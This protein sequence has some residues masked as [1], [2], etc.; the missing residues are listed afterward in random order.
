MRHP[1]FRHSEKTTPLLFN[2]AEDIGCSNNVADTH[3][4]V[5]ARLSALADKAREDLGDAGRPGQNQ[6]QRGQVEN[7]EPQTMKTN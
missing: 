1:H 5:V 6:R 2:V 3:P 7:P 4:D